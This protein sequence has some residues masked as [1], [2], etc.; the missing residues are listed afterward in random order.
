MRPIDFYFWSL[1]IEEQNRTDLIIQMLND[2]NNR[3]FSSH[4]NSLSD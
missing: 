3:T 1:L 4:T 2:Q